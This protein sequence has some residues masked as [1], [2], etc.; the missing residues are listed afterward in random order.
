MTG[1]ENCALVGYYAASNDSSL[2][3]FRYTTF[4]KLPAYEM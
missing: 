3:T 1:K 4:W 2:P